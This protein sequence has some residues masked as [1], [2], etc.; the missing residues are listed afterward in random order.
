MRRHP[1]ENNAIIFAEYPELWC[2]MA[3]MVVKN[4]EPLAPNCLLSCMLLKM[5]DLLEANLICSPAIWADY[6]SPRRR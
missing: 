3:S 2:Y 6:E 4:K 5:P 1:K